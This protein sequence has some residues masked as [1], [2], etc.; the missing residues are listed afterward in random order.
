ME[1][2][3][4]LQQFRTPGMDRVILLVSG[5]AGT[6]A[7]LITL[8]LVYWLWD[9][10]R[11]W[12]MVLVFMLFMQGNTIVKEMTVQPRPYQADTRIG[13]VGP[14]PRSPGFPS[15][16]AQA[17]AL[18][19]GGMAILH[20]AVVPSLLLVGVAAVVGLTRLYLGV[21]DFPD[22]VAGWAFGGLGVVMMALLF[23]L[24]A[25]NAAFLRGWD[26][27]IF[28]VL[29][30]LVL[31]FWAPSEGNL[32]ACTG[33]SAAALLEGVARRFIGF[34]DPRSHFRRLARA[35]IGLMPYVMMIPFLGY[36]GP[37]PALW[38]RV[39]F[40]LAG[41]AWMFLGAPFLFKSMNI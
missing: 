37:E 31:F 25:Q 12:T 39:Q 7:W 17:A 13:L 20:P 11:G 23:R 34:T 32:M 24:Q 40:V 29:L 22:V 3:Y 5:L 27:R 14:P 21:H 6:V 10:R 19:F 4:Y 36:L 15:G 30:G 41:A 8:S 35:L 16:H 18:M 28:W 38:L 33:L 2:I 9:R 1:T 26:V